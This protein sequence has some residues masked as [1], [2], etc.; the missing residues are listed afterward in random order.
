MHRR[1]TALSASG[2]VYYWSF[3]GETTVDFPSHE[4]PNI[5]SASTWPAKP[6]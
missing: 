6:F 4:H 5:E 1:P 2:E 3:L